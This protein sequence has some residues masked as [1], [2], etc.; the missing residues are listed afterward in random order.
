MLTGDYMTIGDGIQLNVLGWSASLC[1][2]HLKR[3][4]ESAESR[5]CSD[6]T[7]NRVGSQWNHGGVT[8]NDC[9][10]HMA[11]RFKEI[12]GMAFRKNDGKATEEEN[13]K[14]KIFHMWKRL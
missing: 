12:H 9:P 6:A 5:K 14:E 3:Y 8:Y 7:C 13:K 1:G 2:E 10:S 4:R 11:E